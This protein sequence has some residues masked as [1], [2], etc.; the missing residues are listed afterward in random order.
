[1]ND[2]ARVDKDQ[3]SALQ[4]RHAVGEPPAPEL[5]P[6]EAVLAAWTKVEAAQDAFEDPP[7]KI[8]VRPWGVFED[9]ILDFREILQGYVCKVRGVHKIVH[10]QCGKRAHMYCSGCGMRPSETPGWTWDDGKRAWRAPQPPATPDGGA[11]PRD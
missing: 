9:A 10:D 2:H 7:E 1:M 11:E 6:L 3:V 8:G 4:T 5:Q